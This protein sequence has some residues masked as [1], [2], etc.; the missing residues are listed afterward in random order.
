ME[1][2]V[3]DGRVYGIKRVLQKRRSKG[4]GKN[5]ALMHCLRQQ[6]EEYFSG[7]RKK[8]NLP[9]VKRRTAFQQKVWKAMAAIPYGQMKSYG[10]IAQKVGHPRAAR[11]VGGACGFNPWLV[12]IPCH[13][14][15]AADGGLG[16]F[17]L[18]L[19]AKKKLLEI[20]Q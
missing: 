4:Y 3:D 7:R 1:L 11:A 6:L 18:G 8:F 16:G 12:V 19:A 5:S 10:Y 13:R 9:L 15:V 2:A 14:I 20:E 17:A